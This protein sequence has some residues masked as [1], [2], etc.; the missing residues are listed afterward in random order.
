[1]RRNAP[2]FAALVAAVMMAWSPPS[3]AEKKPR[4][5]PLVLSV[6]IDRSTIPLGEAPQITLSLTNPNAVAVQLSASSGLSGANARVR[7]PGGKRAITIHPVTL[8]IFADGLRSDASS[9]PTLRPDETYRFELVPRIDDGFT[10][11]ALR[12][13]AAGPGLYLG[14]SDASR[15]AQPKAIKTYYLTGRG[16]YLLQLRYAYSFIQPG[17]ATVTRRTLKSSWIAFTLN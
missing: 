10:Y 1:M 3:L 8:R 13:T 5:K 16:D 6:A 4:L 12:G 2:Q 11:G 17:S 9:G 14:F 7:R 15:P